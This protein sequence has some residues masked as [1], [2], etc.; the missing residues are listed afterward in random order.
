MD[1]LSIGLIFFCALG[2]TLAFIGLSEALGLATARYRQH[3][4]DQ[5]R[6]DLHEQFI[7]LGPH[8]LL[9]I[10]AG[11][12]LCLGAVTLA[13]FP[14]PFVI[15]SAT[16]G[17]ATP[18]IA[19]R[20]IRQRRQQ[21]I[22]QQMPDA[23]QSLAGALRAGANLSKGFEMAARRQPSPIAQ[24]FSLLLGRQRLGES[25][26]EAITQFVTRVPGEESRLFQSAV[27]ISHRV[28]GDLADTLERVGM[29]LR[30]RAQMEG[31]IAA[32]TAMGRMQGRVMCVLPIAIAAMLYVQQPEIMGRLFHEPL[33]WAVMTL[34]AVMMTIAVVS[35]RRI[36]AI[37]V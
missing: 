9:M 6:V 14:W 17:L 22:I 5:L 18:R 37:D 12:A 31:R 36:V 20:L 28:G 11:L 2:G 10:A 27:I 21:K 24:E 8:Q 13:L 4:D 29:T 3:V 15:A 35:I 16:A 19:V 26:E 23:L 1:A 30:E 7:D 34:A 33:G 32:I 25:L